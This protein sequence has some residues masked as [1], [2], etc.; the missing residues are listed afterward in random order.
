MH[1]ALYWYVFGTFANADFDFLYFILCLFQATY[2]ENEIVPSDVIELE[3]NLKFW[4][5]S[6]ENAL[7]ADLIIVQKGNL[8]DDVLILCELQG[9]CVIFVFFS[10]L[11]DNFFEGKPP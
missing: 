7:V 1:E 3:F 2:R 4:D 8:F 9:T 6:P 5:P 11:Y 10:L